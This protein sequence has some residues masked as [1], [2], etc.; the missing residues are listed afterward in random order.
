MQH[1][2]PEHQ[3]SSLTLKSF[4]GARN[5]RF[6]SLHSTNWIIN[7]LSYLNLKCQASEDGHRSLYCRWQLNVLEVP[8]H[9]S[10]GFDVQGSTLMIRML[11][12]KALP[13]KYRTKRDDGVSG[14][15]VANCFFCKEHRT[16]V[17]AP[18]SIE[19]SCFNPFQIEMAYLEHLQQLI[20]TT[21]VRQSVY[22]EI[23]SGGLAG[24]HYQ[25]WR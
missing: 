10:E 4:H 11:E 7:W 2:T 24:E 18:P 25:C 15:R 21:I 16:L 20:C 17:W 23:H 6:Q 13:H 3:R 22:H 14:T 9:R 19:Y 1:R 5:D 12:E 8:Q